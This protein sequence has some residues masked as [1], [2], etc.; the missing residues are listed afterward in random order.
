MSF[1]DQLT[2]IGNRHAMEAFV[3][4]LQPENSIGIVYCDVMGL[5][6]VNDMEGHHA[7]DELLIRAC[8]ALKRTFPHHALFRVGG[9]EFVVL[10]A[11]IAKEELEEKEDLLKQDMKEHSAMMAVGHVWR[12]KSTE[13]IDCLLSEADEK[14]YQDK[15]Q[16][17]AENGRIKP[18]MTEYCFQ[19]KEKER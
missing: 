6:K 7:G 5:K 17:Y 13:N 3:L 11:G 19:S 16:Y 14:M 1:Y 8:Q 15:R 4:S 2:G 9:D 10:C 12:E 18:R